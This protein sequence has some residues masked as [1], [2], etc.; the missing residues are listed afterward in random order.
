MNA[1]IKWSSLQKNVKIFTPKRFYEIGPF[2][3]YLV[4]SSKLPY[5]PTVVSYSC[6]L[7]VTLA[8]VTP[9]A[10]FISYL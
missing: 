1:L 4:D 3:G 5:S 7:F 8:A 10:S 6:K 2:N 9:A